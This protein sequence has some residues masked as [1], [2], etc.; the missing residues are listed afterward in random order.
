MPRQ[1][2]RPAAL[3]MSFCSAAAMAALS[4][5]AA[6]AQQGLPFRALLPLRV[7]GSGRFTTARSRFRGIM[8]R[9]LRRSASPADSALLRC[10]LLD[11]DQ[12]YGISL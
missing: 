7:A 2:R 3:V 9:R 6:A 11:P 8:V 1:T 12:E 4:A 5:G 10:H